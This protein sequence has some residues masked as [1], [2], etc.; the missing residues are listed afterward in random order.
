MFGQATSIKIGPH[1][2]NI[3]TNKLSSVLANTAHVC[4][5]LLTHSVH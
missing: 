5:I 3:Q 1:L 2:N 4:P